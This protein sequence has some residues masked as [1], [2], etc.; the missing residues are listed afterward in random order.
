M[1][2]YLDA[3][4]IVALFVVDLQT[5]RADRFLAGQRPTLVVSDFAEAEFA[6][7]IAGHVRVGRLDMDRARSVFTAFDGWASRTARVETHSADIA[8]TS[9]M[10][11]RLDLVLRTP[12][13]LNIAI[14][15]RT[16]AALATFDEKMA[17][18]AEKIGVPVARV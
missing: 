15:H 14:A 13:A 10:L 1:N 5:E 18:C 4:F 2:V 9:A 6:S 7:A 12:D 11:R 3:S 17:S 8:A 16:G